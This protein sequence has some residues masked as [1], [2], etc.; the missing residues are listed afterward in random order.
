MTKTTEIARPPLETLLRWYELMHT[1]RRFEESA[2]EL[3]SKGLISGS[4]HPSIAQEAISVGACAA[5]RDDDLV[6]ATYRGHGACLAKGAD[7]KVLMA[8]LLG[9]ATGCSKGKGGSMH[10]VDVTHG[11]LGTNAI[12]AAH[13]PIAGGVA[14][15][16]KLRH[17]GQVTV[18]F[19][20]DGAACEGEFFETLNMSAL[21][22][23]PLVLICE[24]NGY[25]ISVETVKSQAT[26]DIADRAKGFGMVNTIVDGN[27]PE[28]VYAAV[29]EAVEHARKGKGPTFVE[30]KTVRWER[31]SG[32]SAGRYADPEAAKRWRTADPIPRFGK[33]LQA[34]GASQEQLEA[35]A[36][37][38]RSIVEEAVEF[39]KASP[40][41]PEQSAFENVFAE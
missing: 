26:P 7:A 5:L 10:L 9:R 4:T 15:S 35:C 38:A 39:A 16:S 40:M 3:Y 41:P 24:N 25:A 30:C 21:W 29:K 14:L 28:A 17:T 12:V 34:L 22:K 1:I 2:V 20:G 11:I 32:F 23:V 33:R 19:F 8:E 31:H 37:R 36:E 13:I 18:C 27:D 6:L